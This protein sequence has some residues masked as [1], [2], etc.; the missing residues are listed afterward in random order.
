MSLIINIKQKMKK[1]KLLVFLL[2]AVMVMMQ[3][4]TPV[5]AT[6]VDEEKEEKIGYANLLICY[7]RIET[8]YNYHVTVME[9]NLVRVNFSTTQFMK[10]GVLLKKVGVENDYVRIDS[11]YEATYHTV[12]F[13]G[14]P[15]EYEIIPIAEY[16]PQTT[17]L[18]TGQN[19]FRGTAKYV[20]LK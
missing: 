20:T 1:I 17:W 7:P 15:G 14:T 6:E 5:M 18:G 2:L 9:N 3:A 16:N 13:Y 12:Y 8:R 4:L 10:G 11:E 19:T